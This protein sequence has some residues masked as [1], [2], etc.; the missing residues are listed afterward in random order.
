VFALPGGNAVR[1]QGT[2]PVSAADLGYPEVQVT[3]TDQAL[4][5]ASAPVPAGLVLLRVINQTSD[6]IGAGV[7]GPPPGQSM[8]AFMAAAQATPSASD[9][10]PAFLYQATIPGGPGDAAAGK[11]SEAVI[12]LPAG[13]WAVFSEGD[14]P[15]A[16]LT[17]SGGT[18]T[19]QEP[20]QTTITVTDQEFAFLGLNQPVPAGPQ[21]W[22]VVNQGQQPHMLLLGTVP[23]GT[24]LQQ[25]MDVISLDLPEG[26]TPPSDMLQDTDVD[27]TVGGV[28][29]QS[30]GQTV[31]P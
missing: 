30:S 3:V 8:E 16:M 4:A 19:S 10:F 1:A 26:A 15:P 12:M 29:L 17:A 7:L 28:I 13:E 5:V 27:F 9:E 25:V 22:E 18:P 11:T 31:Y 23:A 24:T 21:L 14:Q 20:P 6:Q 2:T